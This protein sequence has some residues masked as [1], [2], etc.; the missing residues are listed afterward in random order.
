MKN[1]FLKPVVILA[2]VA[3]GITACQ[4]KKEVTKDDTDTES[5]GIILHNMDTTVSPKTEVGS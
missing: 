4:E 1:K 3:A 2:V 5:H